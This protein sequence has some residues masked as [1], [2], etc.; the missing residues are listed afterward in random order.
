MIDLSTYFFWFSKHNMNTSITIGATLVNS[1]FVFCFLFFKRNKNEKKELL[2]LLANV[3]RKRK[4]FCL[5]SLDHIV[6]ACFK[7]LYRV[8]L[9]LVIIYVYVLFVFDYWLLNAYLLDMY[10]YTWT[11][12]LDFGYWPP[13][14]YSCVVY[15]S[16]CVLLLSV[17]VMCLLRAMINVTVI[18]SIKLLVSG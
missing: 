11:L 9:H 14:R 3:R 18:V 12:L 8:W 7:G 4:H 15:A 16:A 2:F 1:F 13:C 17:A 10:L 5:E 6:S